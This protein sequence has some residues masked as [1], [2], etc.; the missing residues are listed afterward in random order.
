MIWGL[1]A[2]RA[3]QAASQPFAVS[4]MA[5]I[6]ISA[7]SRSFSNADPTLLA[8]TVAR[9]SVPSRPASQVS[10]VS[11]AAARRAV[12]APA[13]AAPSALMLAAA[14][15]MNVPRT[16]PLVSRAAVIVVHK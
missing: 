4:R 16:P 14:R 8:L 11:L 1:L 12:R 5:A 10:L 13:P 2:R 15:K 6:V 7:A 9:R 3:R